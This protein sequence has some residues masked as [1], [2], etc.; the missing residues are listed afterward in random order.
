MLQSNGRLW[1]DD[2][3]DTIPN[4]YDSDADGDGSLDDLDNNGLVDMAFI[5][6]PWDVDNDADGTAD[7]IWVDLGMP[8]KTAPDGRL[9]KPLYAILCVDL[10]G[11]LNVNAHGVK[12]F[13]VAG[14]P[15]EELLGQQLLATAAGTPMTL[16]VTRGQGYGPAEIRLDT[17]VRDPRELPPVNTLMNRLIARRYGGYGEADPR[18]GYPGEFSQG[19][20]LLSYLQQWGVPR[21]FGLQFNANP[22][23]SLYLTPPDLRGLGGVYLDR[24]GQGQYALM[25]TA[26]GSVPVETRGRPV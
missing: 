19:V 8:I 16:D 6:G 21:E 10:D 26:L 7:S 9:Y 24:A 18:P 4:V 1:P 15:L 13:E 17:A 22:R 12:E 5:N 11:R 2:D 14:T 3:N 20:D 23:G 25:G